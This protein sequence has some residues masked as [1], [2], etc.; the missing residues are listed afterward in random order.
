MKHFNIF[1]NKTKIIIFSAL[2]SLISGCNSSPSGQIKDPVTN[3][4]CSAQVEISG[5][6]IDCEISRT[7]DG[8]SEISVKSPSELEGLKFKWLGN[9]FSISQHDL[10][11]ETPTPFLPSNSFAMS[12]VS[13]LNEIAKPE[14]LNLVSSPKDSRTYSGNCDSG[15]FQVIVDDKSGFINEIS[16]ENNNNLKIHFAN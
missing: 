4:N 13:A 14:S 11:C 5:T 7:A 15:K 16:F 10:S 8:I 9:G 3:F 2:C 12:I 6:T 1:F